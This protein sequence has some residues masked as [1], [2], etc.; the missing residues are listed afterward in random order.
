MKLAALTTVILLRGEVVGVA[1][2]L[3]W[4]SI[5]HFVDVL[6]EYSEWRRRRP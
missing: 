4:V 1:F 5:V 3:W 2:W 6:K